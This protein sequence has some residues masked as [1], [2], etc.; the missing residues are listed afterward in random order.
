MTAPVLRAN[1]E[2]V[3]A[4]WIASIPEW[5]AGVASQLPQDTST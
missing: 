5:Q 3:A 1:S 4:A 2:L